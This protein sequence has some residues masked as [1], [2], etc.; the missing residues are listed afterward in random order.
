MRQRTSIARALINQAED[1]ADGRTVL[2]S[3]TNRPGASFR[4]KLV[5]DLGQGEG[6]DYL[7]SPTPLTR[8][9]ILADRIVVMTPRPGRIHTIY[10]MTEY[11]RPRDETS[12]EML[13]IKQEISEILKMK[14]DE[15][16]V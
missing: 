15:E 16:G 2:R 12:K 3:W 7:S 11:P 9:L 14:A 5:K 8:R 10:N 6:Y 1:A 4:T 13:T